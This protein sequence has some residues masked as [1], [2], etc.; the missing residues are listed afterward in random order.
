MESSIKQKIVYMKLSK[1]TIDELIKV[2]P[3]LLKTR[4]NTVSFIKRFELGEGNMDLSIAKNLTGIIDALNSKDS[5]HKE[6]LEYALQLY[7]KKNPDAGK[8]FPWGDQYHNDIHQTDPELIKQLKKD[9]YLI[10]N[11]K[12]VKSLPKELETSALQDELDTLL[13]KYEL[14]TAKG[15]LEQA[16]SIYRDSNWAGAN[17]QIRSFWESVLFFIVEKRN[18]DYKF[19]DHKNGSEAITALS[20]CFFKQELNEV[21]TKNSPYGFVKGML[22]MLHP[23]GSHPGLSEEPATT[24]RL[25]LVIATANYYLKR[26]DKQLKEK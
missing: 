25:H 15:H 17:A 18:P 10:R 6:V 2:L 5:I 14:E 24:F 13:D 23:D 7:Y 21:D 20:G 12:T 22:K 11:R 16:I 3:D 19:K 1:P 26:L 8:E 4:A 9:G